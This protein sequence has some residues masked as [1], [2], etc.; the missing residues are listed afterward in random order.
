[1]TLPTSSTSLRQNRA[2]VLM[3]FFAQGFVFV[4]AT[5]FIPKI[6][7]E[8]GLDP[9]TFSLFLLG[10][11]LAAAVGSAIAEAV[12]RRAGSAAALRAGLGAMVPALALMFATGHLVGLAAG[13]VL[14]GITLGMVDAGSNMQAVTLERRYGRPVLPSSQGAWT[15]G[16]LLATGVSLAGVSTLPLATGAAFAV[17]P[18]V[19]ALAP[20]QGRS[21]L[22]PDAGPAVA[23]SDAGP[24]SALPASPS[25]PVTAPSRGEPSPAPAAWPVPV[26]WAAIAPAGIAF[27][28]YYLVDSATQAWGPL[29]L[30]LVLATPEQ[31]L[32]LATLP[33]LAATWLV[34]LAGDRL[35][36]RFGAPALVRVGA[37]IAFAGLAA[38]V[39]APSWPVAA[40]G[41]FATGLG[42]GTVAP[43]SFS[44]A[45]R[46]AGGN[47]ARAD[48]VVA[49][50]NQLNYVGA[51]LG[52]VVTGLVSTGSSLR[53]G[54]ALPLVLVLVLVPL[55]RGFGTGHPNAGDTGSRRGGPN[56]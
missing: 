42:L 11:V 16:G 53:I 21:V 40:A 13:M 1:M 15:L 6:T 44:A 17:V 4:S 2:A 39:L 36:A 5:L 10:M 20:L 27:L 46:I 33:Y 56:R 49:R 47:R 48:V 9:G 30:N 7:R 22:V 51:L 25:A 12:A 14:Y 38:V 37:M 28:I 50:F 31:L 52:A 43:L 32:A 8:F 41:F 54:F 18:L 23:V 34:R 3:A 24:G 29:Y 35:T 55:A 19:A 45:A 26:P